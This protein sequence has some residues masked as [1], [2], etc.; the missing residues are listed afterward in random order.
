MTR[1]LGKAQSPS[2]A[3]TLDPR[4]WTLCV[5]LSTGNFRATPG[6]LRLGAR[7]LWVPGF[8]SWPGSDSG[9]ASCF[10][11]PVPE[12]SGCP[13]VRVPAWDVTDVLL[14]PSPRGFD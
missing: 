5:N 1:A 4:P 6:G 11:H 9:H 12:G 3:L 7:L 10:H 13:G 2:Q 8:G 14:P